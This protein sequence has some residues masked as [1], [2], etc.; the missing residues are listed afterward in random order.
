MTAWLVLTGRWNVF[1]NPDD[2]LPIGPFFTSI[3]LAALELASEIYWI[4]RFING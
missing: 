1:G 2:G 3:V 4:E